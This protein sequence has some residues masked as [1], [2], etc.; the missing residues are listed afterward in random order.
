MFGYQYGGGVVDAINQCDK[1]AFSFPDYSEQDTI[2]QGFKSMSA[3][4]FDCVSRVVRK[5]MEQRWLSLE[6]NN[7]LSDLISSPP[8]SPFIFPEVILFPIEFKAHREMKIV[9]LQSPREYPE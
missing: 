9:Q 7:V 4:S 1:L 3:A 8:T 6:T 2:S 5:E